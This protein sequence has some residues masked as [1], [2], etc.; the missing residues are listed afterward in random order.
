MPVN[1]RQRA[2][3]LIKAGFT[4]EE[5]AEFAKQYSIAQMR[6]LPYMIRM[7]RW[8]NLYCVNL[9]SKGYGA[10]EIERSIYALYR[11]K[12]WL[13]SDGQPDAWQMLKAFRKVAI[14]NN[15]YIPKKRPHRARA[16]ITKRELDAQS[17]Q[18]KIQRDIDKEVGW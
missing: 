9:A 17:R 4:V 10:E 12:G 18:L 5:S 13:T 15:E 7:R 2:T 8:R 11:K 16:E 3:L 6:S 14:A 1:Y